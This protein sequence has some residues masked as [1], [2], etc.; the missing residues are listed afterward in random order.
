[1]V[2]TLL[3]ALPSGSY[4]VAS[5][6]TTDFSDPESA[7]RY[8]AMIDAG[9]VDAFPRTAAEMSEIFTGLDVPRIAAPGGPTPR[10]ARSTGRHPRSRAR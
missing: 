5:N 1:M 2:H 10:M 4:L 3:D 8:R 7:A 6:A 9:E